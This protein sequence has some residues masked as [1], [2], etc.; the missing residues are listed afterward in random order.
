MSITLDSLPDEATRLTVLLLNKV[1]DG[2][3]VRDV[4]VRLWDGTC[5][6]D[7]APRQ[8]TLVLNHPGAL[9][10]MFLPGSELGL[11]EAYLYDDFDIKGNV[12]TVFGLA[13]D[14]DQKALGGLQ[15]LGIARDLLRLPAGSRHEH[16]R[17]GPAKL[18]R[19]RHLTLRHWVRRLEAHHKEALQFVD[20]PTYRVWRLF[21]SGSAHG[22][23]TGRLNVYQTLLLRPGAGRAVCR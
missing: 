2:D 13:E 12:E 1:F 5:W 11:A 23:T 15:K 9:R 6:P 8:A 10:A 16:G 17:R 14:L 20:E 4:G 3:A 21:M 22:F 18:Q 19:E 7:A